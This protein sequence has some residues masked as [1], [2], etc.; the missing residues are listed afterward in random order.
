MSKPI[1]TAAL[2]AAVDRVLLAFPP[3]KPRE[4]RL[5]D[6]RAILRACGGR[7]AVFEKLCAVFQESLPDQV[8]LVRSALRDDD[9]SRLREAAHKLYGTLGTFSTIAGAVALT[10]EDAAIREDLDSC[11]ELVDRL[12]SMCSE[13]LEDMRTLTID[14]L[15]L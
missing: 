13:L 8:A 14:G 3:A 12:E 1:E 6:P 4:S 7:A 9:L 15:S 11:A 10:I 5:V 2:W